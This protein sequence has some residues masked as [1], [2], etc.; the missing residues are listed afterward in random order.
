MTTE[1]QNLIDGLRASLTD[2]QLEA[3]AFICLFGAGVHCAAAPS[4][5]EERASGGAGVRSTPHG[6]H[7]DN[8]SSVLSVSGGELS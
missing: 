2:S 7:G 5:S 1:I 3:M 8:V 4:M 6:N